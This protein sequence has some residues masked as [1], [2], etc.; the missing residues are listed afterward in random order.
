MNESTG[1]V[2]FKTSKNAVKYFGTRIM[3][4]SVKYFGT[5][6]VVVNAIQYFLTN[7]R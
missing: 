6:G 4:K 3:E 2:K 7:V 5:E 1:E